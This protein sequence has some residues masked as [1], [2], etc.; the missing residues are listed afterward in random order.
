MK[1]QRALLLSPRSGSIGTNVNRITGPELAR[2]YR[3]IV[4]DVDTLPLGRL[5]AKL[6]LAKLCDYRSVL[7]ESLS[8]MEAFLLLTQVISNHSVTPEIRDEANGCLVE[9]RFSNKIGDS[10]LSIDGALLLL[11]K[12]SEPRALIAVN[13]LDVTD[14]AL[15]KLL[16]KLKGAVGK[17]VREMVRYEPVLV[18]HQPSPLLEEPPIAVNNLLQIIEQ[19]RSKAAASV[20]EDGYFLLKI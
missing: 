8:R 9:W 4:D 13:T 6:E 18:F 3:D 7:E 17:K 16:I 14:R 10:E 20:A 1:L 15:V 5:R 19:P 2:M 12:M 11:K